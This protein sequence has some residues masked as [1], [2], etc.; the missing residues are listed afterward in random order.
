MRALYLAGRQADA[1]ALYRRTRETFADEIGVEPSPELQRL[2]R[3]ILNHDSA[4]GTPAR[5]TRQPV[6]GAGGCSSW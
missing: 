4:L 1:L 2:E 3:A 6:A 5:A